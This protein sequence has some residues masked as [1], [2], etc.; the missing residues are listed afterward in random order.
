[1]KSAGQN[2]GEVKREGPELQFLNSWLSFPLKGSCESE[3]LNG[4]CLNPKLL[5][6]VSFALNRTPRIFPVD[7]KDEEDG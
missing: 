5:L 6:V 1:M 2:R 4:Y 7:G 3:T